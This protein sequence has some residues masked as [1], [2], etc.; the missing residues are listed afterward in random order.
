MCHYCLARTVSPH[1]VVARCGI[2]WQLMGKES[3]MI[4]AIYLV[5]HDTNEKRLSNRCH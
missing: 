1:I 3:I 5:N 2:T 4:G